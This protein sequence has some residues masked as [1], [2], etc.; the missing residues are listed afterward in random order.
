[1]VEQLVGGLGVDG[2]YIDQLAAAGPVLD[3]APGRSHGTG[4]GSWWSTGIS[5][6]LAAIRTKTPDAPVAVE[7]N[8]EDKI[9]VVQAMLVPSSFHVPFA[10]NGSDGD[11]AGSRHGVHAPAFAAVYG[12]YSVF[13]GDIYGAADLVHPDVLCAKLAGTFCAGTQ[14]V[15]LV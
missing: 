12:G 6:M 3:F 10:R 8:A 5:G 4:G 13:F 15:G 11:V 14:L 1:M 9:G 7:G 2:V